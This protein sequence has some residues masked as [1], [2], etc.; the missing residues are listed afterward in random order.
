MCLQ[1]FLKKGSIIFS[2]F[3]STPSLNLKTYIE[4]LGNLEY[5]KYIWKL[6]NLENFKS[7]GNLEV[8]KN[9]KVRN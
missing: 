6:G 3:D 4:I 7:L 8:S 2:A 1:D 9:F 5:L